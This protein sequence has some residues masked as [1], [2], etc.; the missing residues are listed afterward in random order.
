MIKTLSFRG[1]EFKIE[2]YE[3][4]QGDPS[5]YS[6]EDE[7]SVRNDVWNIQSGDIIFDV[8]CAYGSYSIPALALGASHIYCW[9]P[10]NFE[11]DTLEKTLVHNNWTDKATLFRTGVY[12]KCGFLDPMTQEFS[13]DLCKNEMFE[14]KILNQFINDIRH[15]GRSWLKM[16][17]EG[18]EYEV[19]KSSVEFLTKFKPNMVIENHEFKISGIGMLIRNFLV[20]LGFRHIQTIPYHAVSHSFYIHTENQ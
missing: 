8:G 4:M 7:Q 19:I 1:K 11:M 20:H 5:W 9:N 16:D 3:N 15:S 2:Y 6:F 13:L 12:G 17:I 14:V 10:I 18:A